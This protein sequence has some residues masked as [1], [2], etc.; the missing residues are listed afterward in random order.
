MPMHGQRCGTQLNVDCNK[1]G[2]K[3]H[4]STKQTT[5]NQDK[6]KQETP[7]SIVRF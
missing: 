3:T 7:L 2:K 1:K 4:E 5:K 6:T